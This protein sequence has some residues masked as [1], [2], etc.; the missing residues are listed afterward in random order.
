MHRLPGSGGNGAAN[1]SSELL[2]GGD[3]KQILSPGERLLWSGQPGYGRVLLQAV[4]HERL[5][6]ICLL[7]GAAVMR[8]TMAV[9][10]FDARFRRSEA[11][12]DLWGNY[13]RLCSVLF[14]AGLATA[15]RPIKLGSYFVTDRRVILCRRGRN[16]RLDIGLYVISCAHPPGFPYVPVPGRPH[17]S[18]QVG[19]VLSQDQVQPWG[20][21]THPGQPALWGRVSTPVVLEYLPDATGVLA[22]IRS[23]TG[24]HRRIEHRFHEGAIPPSWTAG[25]KRLLWAL[26]RDQSSDQ[27]SAVSASSMWPQLFDRTRR[28]MGSKNSSGL[29]G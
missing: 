14:R 10:P 22:L 29:V 4:G 20:G 17:A 18:V 24:P 8:A 25:G 7:V 26:A 15:V 28:S 6:H 11:F 13:G 9:L 3:L 27:S 21:L 19:L 12:L 23:C 5:V 1:C 2:S 16:W